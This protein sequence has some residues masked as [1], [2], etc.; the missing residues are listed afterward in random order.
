MLYEVAMIQEPTEKEKDDG[1]QEVLVMPPTPVIAKDEQTAGVSAVMMKKD[2][3]KCEI[4][5]IKVLVR[6]FA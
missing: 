2:E 5:R 3:I 6:P 4:S 1:M